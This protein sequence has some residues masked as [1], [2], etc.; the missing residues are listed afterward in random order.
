MPDHSHDRSKTPVWAPIGA[1]LG[2]RIRGI[3]LAAAMVVF[4][5]L[6]CDS[7]SADWL[8]YPSTYSH[9]TVTG[10]RVAQ[11]SPI[12]APTTA[13]AAPLRVGGFNHFRSSLQYGASAD[14]YHRVESFGAPVQPYGQWRF[15]FRPFSTPYPNWGPPFAGVGANIQ[16]FGG[17]NQLGGGN[18]LSANRWGNGYQPGLPPGGFIG[19]PAI[20]GNP[21]GGAAPL[22]QN[23][24]ASPFN[25]YPL[26][27]GNPTTVPPYFDG[28]YPILRN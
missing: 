16:L 26:S 23:P 9:D 4:S 27:P 22:F 20:P 19:R 17:G 11:Y 2:E 10:Q 7:A 25:P 18:P 14:H 6:F 12:A 3:T 5:V 1:S 21:I 28:S 15:P 8:T 24:Q 13:V